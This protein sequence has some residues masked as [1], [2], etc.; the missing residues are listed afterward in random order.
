VSE[1]STEVDVAVVGSGISGLAAAL[2]EAQRG[3]RVAV[4][5]KRPSIGGTSN[6]FEGIFRNW[7]ILR[8]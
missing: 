4:F 7:Q 5:E 6:F 2:E 8:K 3:S 1:I